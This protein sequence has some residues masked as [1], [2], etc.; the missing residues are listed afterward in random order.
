MYLKKPNK[1]NGSYQIVYVENDELLTRNTGTKIKAEAQEMLE[2]LEIAELSRKKIEILQGTAHIK[3]K[4]NNLWEIYKDTEPT[5]YP[6]ELRKRQLRVSR[7]VDYLRSIN[8]Y[9]LNRITPKIAKRYA[10]QLKQKKVK[11]GLIKNKT[12]NDKIKCFRHIFKEI[13]CETDLR[14]NPFSAVKL[15]SE[16]DSRHGR[17]FTEKEIDE[18][19]QRCIEVG[20]EWYELVVIA[21][22]T[23][24][25][26]VD[27]CFLRWTDIKTIENEDGSIDKITKIIPRKT[28]KTKNKQTFVIPPDLEPMLEKQKK[29]NSVYVLPKR[30]KEYVPNQDSG[31]NSLILRPCGIFDTDENKIWIHCTRHTLTTLIRDNGADDETAMDMTGLNNLSTLKDYDKSVKKMTD[32]SKNIHYKLPRGE[33]TE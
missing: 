29:L 8:I 5:C 16:N 25:R 11:G 17:P 20:S 7:F 19:L 33:Q 10:K 22:Y 9:D 26:Y 27:C 28:R 21:L 1:K 30:K 14:E 12:Y 4:I 15:E 3:I 23:G 24:M 18:I 13:L 32:I 2:E 31:F 6:D